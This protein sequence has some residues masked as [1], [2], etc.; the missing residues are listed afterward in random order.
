MSR[1]ID[2]SLLW[3]RRSRGLMPRGLGLL[4]V[5]VCASVLNGQV[6]REAGLVF[7]HPQLEILD[8]LAG[9]WNVRQDHFDRRGKVF[10][11]V[12]GTETVAWVLDHHAIRREYSTKSASAL[13]SAIGY[14]TWND[15]SKNFEGVWFDNSS[16]AGPT[17]V[18]GT[19]DP[20]SRT[21]TFSAEGPDPNR[22]GGRRN[23][24]V[25]D[26]FESET[27]RVATTYL[28]EGSEVVKLLQVR[29]ERATPCPDRMRLIFDH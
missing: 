1:T 20:E 4:V 28:L 24:R 22:L 10:E 8:F 15:A 19:W 27:T 17:T 6:K 23:Y 18:R 14:L 7:S 11:T 9:T 2:Q 5:L 12:S 16:L 25:V 3:L 29:Y 21:M 13:Y 26:R